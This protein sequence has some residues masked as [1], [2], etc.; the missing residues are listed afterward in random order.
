MSLFFVWLFTC[1]CVYLC[2]CL[3]ICLFMYFSYYEDI[4]KLPKVTEDQMTEEMNS[5]SEVNIL[6]NKIVYK[7][8]IFVY[9][10]RN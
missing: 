1:Q 9:I 6:N 5:L 2:I 10:Y 8:L 7:I 4:K 3:Y